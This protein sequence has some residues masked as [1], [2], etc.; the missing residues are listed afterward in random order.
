MFSA[1]DKT[2]NTLSTNQQVIQMEG[3]INNSNWCWGETVEKLKGKCVCGKE[4]SPLLLC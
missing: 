3:F 1:C 4:F 2:K